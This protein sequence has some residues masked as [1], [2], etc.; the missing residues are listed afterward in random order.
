MIKKLIWLAIFVG[1]GFGVYELG[2][3]VYT[4]YDAYVKEENAK[5][6]VQI[7]RTAQD[8]ASPAT[9]AAGH[10]VQNVQKKMDNL[11]RGQDVSP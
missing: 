10:Q 2:D 5:Q 9:S 4:K 7:N 1:I 6:A 8:L 11:D 3:W